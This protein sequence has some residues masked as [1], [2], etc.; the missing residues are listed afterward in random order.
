MRGAIEQ[1]SRFVNRK[2][3][4]LLKLS[5]VKKEKGEDPVDLDFLDRQVGWQVDDGDFDFNKLRS[6]FGICR[7]N[8]IS[9]ELLSK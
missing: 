1:T 8:P 4:P 7:Q 9:V 3:P 5:V 6:F 2:E